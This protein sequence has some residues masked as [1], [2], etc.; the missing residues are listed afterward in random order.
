MKLPALPEAVQCAAIPEWNLSELV[1]RSCPSCQKDLPEVLCDRPDGLVVC[2]CS[3]CQ[4]IYIADTPTPNDVTRFYSRYAD[5]KKLV[6]SRR[7]F[8]SGLL[9]SYTDAHVSF[10]ATTGGIA[11]KK[12]A[13]IGCAYGKFLDLVKRRGADIYGVEIDQITRDA[14]KKKKVPVC[15]RLSDFNIK[16][17]VVTAFQLFEHLVD[18]DELVKE[19]AASIKQDGRLLICVPNG[20]SA[21]TVGASWVGFRVDLEHFNYFTPKSLGN[22]LF[23][24]GFVIEHYWQ[25]WQPHISRENRARKGRCRQYLDTA[26]SRV[27]AS[28]YPEA[29]IGNT[30]DYVLGV[31]AR[32]I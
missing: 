11:K 9:R 22:L 10:L 8:I 23:R 4:M 7:G 6:P 32:K 31:L 5:F 28:L 2:L 21:E 30:G 15:P 27:C 1:H 3:Q 14:L 19:C 12:I 24:H 26:L 16:F 29:R 18:P 17:D 13:D 20:L 25:Y